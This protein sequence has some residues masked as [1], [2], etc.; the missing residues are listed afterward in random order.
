MIRLTLIFAALLT[1][2]A[3]ADVKQLEECFNRLNGRWEEVYRWI[4]S[5]WGT[6]DRELFQIGVHVELM[7][8]NVERLRALKVKS[9]ANEHLLANAVQACRD[10]DGYAEK[11]IRSFYRLGICFGLVAIALVVDLFMLLFLGDH[12]EKK[13][14]E[15]QDKAETRAL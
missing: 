13:K 6:F 10:F 4:P 5:G 12:S 7:R 14:P 3:H 11:R 15:P 8:D 1:V 9:P 2:Q